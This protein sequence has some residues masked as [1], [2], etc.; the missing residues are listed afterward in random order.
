MW[1][2]ESLRKVNKPKRV[3]AAKV[4]EAKAKQR[5]STSAAASSPRKRGKGIE[6]MSN[7]NMVALLGDLAS[8]ARM[9]SELALVLRDGIGGQLDWTAEQK[10]FVR[11]I[12]N[13]AL[14]KVIAD[15]RLRA[16]RKMVNGGL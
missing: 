2:G 15:E 13:T 14:I 5:K 6:V 4:A 11:R 3:S 9:L 16:I 12:V 1:T 7:E 10:R 8:P